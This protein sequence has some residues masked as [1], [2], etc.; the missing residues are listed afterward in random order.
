MYV[1]IKK[2]P[3]RSS[4]ET[5]W[6]NWGLERQTDSSRANRAPNTYLFNNLLT[7]LFGDKKKKMTVNLADHKL[8]FYFALYAKFA[9]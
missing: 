6:G 8:P 9:F 2:N 4:A 1:T 3:E 5:R 7:K